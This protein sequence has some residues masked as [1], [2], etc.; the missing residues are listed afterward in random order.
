M[1]TQVT[2]V[3]LPSFETGSG[4]VDTT[5]Q[6]LG[7]AMVRKNLVIRANGSNTGV[8]LIGNTPQDAAEGYILGKGETTPPIYVDNL[9]KV[10]LVGSA[11]GQ[12]YSWIAT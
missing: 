11:N 4:S 6:P 9:C 8:I 1:I 10:F 3:A 2:D 12:G 7:I 5:P